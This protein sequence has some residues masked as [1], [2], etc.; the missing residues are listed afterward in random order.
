M[1]EGKEVNLYDV[2]YCCWIS[3]VVTRRISSSPH[4][5]QTQ[6]ISHHICTLCTVYTVYTY[7]RAQSKHT[8]STTVY[9][10]SSKLGPHPLSLRRVC[11]V[12]P[13]K[14]KEGKHTRFRARG[15]GSPNSDDLRKSLAL[16]LLCAY[17]Y[18]VSLLSLE[19][20]KRLF[21]KESPHDVLKLCLF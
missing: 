12:C 3:F 10:P 20:L 11:N 5:K 15:W 1:V 18:H 7:V 16:C 4:I 6:S 8:Q 14:P 2:Q 13:P 17:E 19:L 9:V 21:L